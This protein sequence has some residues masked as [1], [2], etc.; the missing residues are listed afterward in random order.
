ME[1]VSTALQRQGISSTPA[2]MPWARVLE[3]ADTKGMVV[4]CVWHT[5]ERAKQFLF[6]E[7]FLVNRISLLKRRELKLPWQTVSDL[8]PYTFVVERKA[9]Y[10][11]AFDDADYLI[12]H[13]V[14]NIGLQVKM[15]ANHH[16][17]IA[18]IAEGSALYHL[19]RLPT[20]QREHL[21]FAQRS[22]VIN[23]LHIMVSRKVP[24][25]HAIIEAFNAG[26]KSMLADGSYYRILQHYQLQRFS[27]PPDPLLSEDSPGLLHEGNTH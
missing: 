17:D 2:I 21:N 19:S 5:E 8:K 12:R 16:M 26:L 4:A 15:I 25:H 13:S 20:E 14:A 23:N 7:P 22:L 10:G 18:P 27:Y 3:L 1:I 9:S 11:K 6:S 24:N